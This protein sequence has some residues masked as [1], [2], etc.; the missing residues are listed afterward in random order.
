MKPS[1]SQLFKR[2]ITLP[3]IGEIGQEKLQNASVL[4]VG[5]GGLGGLIAVSLAASGIGEL[6]LADFDTVSISNLHRQL[7]FSVAD[8]NKPKATVLSAVIKA[9]SP[10]TK[11]NFTTKPITKNS[12]FDIIK[13]VDIIVDATDSLPIKYLLNDACVLKNK[14]L[15]YGSLYKF[16]GYVATFN[17]SENNGVFSAN[18]RDAFPKIAT[19]VPNC[20]EVGTLNS[21]VNIIAALQ[22]NEVLKLITRIGKTLKNEL[23]IYNSLENTQLKMTLKKSVSKENIQEIFEKETYFDVNCEIRNNEWLISAD[24]LKEELQNEIS[25]QSQSKPILVSVI[26]DPTINYPFKIDYKT[27]LLKLKNDNFKLEENKKYVFICNKGNASYEA[28]KLIRE[29][30]LNIDSYS[31]IGGITNY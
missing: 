20:S 29:K 1:K 6:Y 30:H 4:V 13:D 31:L 14:T 26:E 5:C 8:V 15:V 10:F 3:E 22:V 12:I 28:T 25:S 24:E 11:V 23:L 27:S 19:D 18:L 21:I 2:Q 7:F 17:S 9:R 16:D